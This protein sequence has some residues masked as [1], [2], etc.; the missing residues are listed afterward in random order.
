MCIKF[1][2]NITNLYKLTNVRS[3]SKVKKIIG[4]FTIIE[5]S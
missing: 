5:N 3:N 1:K 2:I 4:V